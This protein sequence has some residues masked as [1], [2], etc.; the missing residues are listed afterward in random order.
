MIP[1]SFSSSLTCIYS[2]QFIVQRETPN[3]LLVVYSAV[4]FGVTPLPLIL[5]P[6]LYVTVQ[7]HCLLSTVSALRIH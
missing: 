4:C 6:L 2:S 3:P 1:H 5:N 7:T